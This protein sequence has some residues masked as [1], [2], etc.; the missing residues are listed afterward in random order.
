M[1]LSSEKTTWSI[2]LK[3][4][5]TPVVLEKPGLDECPPDIRA[6]GVRVSPMIFIAM[7]KSPGEPTSRTHDGT[8]WE[9]RNQ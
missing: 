5:C 3:E 7:D 2:F 6:K 8:C 9:D 4:M 1:D